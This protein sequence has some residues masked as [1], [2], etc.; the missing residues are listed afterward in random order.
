[1]SPIPDSRFPLVVKR[2]LWK[3]MPVSGAFLNICSIV[4][5]E[6]NPPPLRH[7]S[8]GFFRER[9]SIPSDPFI[10]LSKS[11]VDEPSS[12]FTKCERYRNRCPSPE[13]FLHILRG[14]QQGNPP[15]RFPSQSS[16]K[17]RH[18]TSRAPFNHIS[19]SLVYEPTPDC[20]AEPP[21]RQMSVSRVFLS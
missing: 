11:T 18:S 5:N 20:P 17:Q 12:R 16:H 19:K 8:R 21:W 2:P 3:E 13:P 7:P 14:P 1:M 9:R 10:Q 6:G 4:P 15:S